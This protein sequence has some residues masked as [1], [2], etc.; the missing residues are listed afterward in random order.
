MKKNIVIVIILLMIVWIATIA[1]RFQEMS[2]DTHSLFDYSK[3]EMPE[4]IS[5][6]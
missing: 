5:A 6:Q 3:V 2:D 1:F 4:E